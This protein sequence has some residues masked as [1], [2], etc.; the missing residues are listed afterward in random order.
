MWCHLLLNYSQVMLIQK[1]ESFCTFGVICSYFVTLLICILPDKYF[2]SRP[3]KYYLK[4]RNSVLHK[5]EHKDRKCGKYRRSP[6]RHFHNLLSLHD[7]GWL[8]LGLLGRAFSTS[9]INFA[10]RRIILGGDLL[11][12]QMSRY[13]SRTFWNHS[14]NVVIYTIVAGPLFL[15]RHRKPLSGTA[16]WPSR[17]PSC[18]TVYCTESLR[19][20]FHLRVR[21]RLT[22]KCATLN[23]TLAVERPRLPQPPPTAE[24]RLAC[25]RQTVFNLNGWVISWGPSAVLAFL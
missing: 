5:L 1:T 22:V 21:C 14:F 18:S 16:Q 15:I 17:R 4:K 25:D 3:I 23:R 2:G 11:A 20:Q 13:F 10:T 6:A 7:Q 8:W 9:I 12:N 19:A 24:T